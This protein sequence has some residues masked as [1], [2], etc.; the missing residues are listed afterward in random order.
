[1][2]TQDYSENYHHE[3]KKEYQSAYFVE[4]GSTVYGMVIR[5]HLADIGTEADLAARGLAPVISDVHRAC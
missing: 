2:S 5:V 1:M 4:I 3:A